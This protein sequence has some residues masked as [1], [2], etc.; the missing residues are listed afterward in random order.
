MSNLLVTLVNESGEHT[1]TSDRENA[2]RG[3]GKLH[4]AFSIFIFKTNEVLLQKRASHKLFGNLWTNTCCSHP[5]PEEEIIDA[6][7]RRLQEE[8]DITCDLK[9]C[10]SFIYKAHDEKGTE[11]EYDTVFVGQLADD[12]TITP[13]MNEITEWKWMD[14]QQLQKDL[15]KNPHHYTPWLHQALLL[16]YSPT[17]LPA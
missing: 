4:R 6:A 8:L 9:E 11:Y 15:A 13:D 5:R 7:K 12:T 3:E 2:H 14:I 17:S 1:G 16:A 10:G